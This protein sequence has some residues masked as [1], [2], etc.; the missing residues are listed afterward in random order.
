[1]IAKRTLLSSIIIFSILNSGIAFGLTTLQHN[2]PAPVFSANE[3]LIPPNSH[4]LDLTQARYKNETPNKK[5]ILGFNISGFIQGASTAN[6]Y[7]GCNEYGSVCGQTENGFELG[8]FRGTMYVMG[9][10]LG[11][12]PIHGAHLGQTI[13]TCGTAPCTGGDDTGNVNSITTTSIKNFGL[14][15]CLE[16]IAL[17]LTGNSLAPLTP[18]LATALV[19]NPTTTVNQ[20]PSIF[21]EGTLAT[22]TVYFGAFSMPLEYRKQ[23][24]RF[25]MNIACGDHIGLTAQTGFANIKQRFLTSFSTQ[26]TVSQTNSGPYSISAIQTTGTTTVPLSNLYKNLNFEAAPLIPPANTSAQAL[27]D[28]NISN[29]LATILDPECG[30]NQGICSFDD[31]SIEDISLFLTAKGRFILNEEKRES[32]GNS[33]PDMMFTPYAYIACAI[34][35]AKSIDYSN[36]LSLP[37][38]NNGHFATGTAIGMTFDFAESVEVGFEAGITYFLPK[39]E[40]RPFPTHRLQRVLYPFSTEVKTKPGAN[41][42]FKAL[43]SAYQFIK[44]INF[45][46]TYELTEH[47]EDCYRICD[48][49]VAQYF[50]PNVLTCKSDWRSQLFNT[51][52]SFDIQP[53]MQA[54]IAWQQPISVR[55][56]YYPV[57]VTG[58]INFMF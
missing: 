56:A 48:S 45:W 10:F 27:F 49:S 15:S 5:R 23:G 26:A 36:L 9:L 18:S 39:K 43:L 58:S 41:G 40:Y 28:A 14:P 42:H 46:F 12:N 29:N 35:T 34:P 50:V 2:D 20:F 16:T 47:R 30:H 32:D 52:L 6:G 11:A 3:S 57:S 19:F 55:N 25:E 1:M 38:G 53:G 7:A 51:G 44:H 54:S 4:F 13:W 31:Y 37:F 22:D 17:N 33:W 24:A 8:D 21:H